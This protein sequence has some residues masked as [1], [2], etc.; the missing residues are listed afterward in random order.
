MKLNV[1]YTSEEKQ[2]MNLLDGYRLRPF[3]LQEDSNTKT[4]FVL[5]DILAALQLNL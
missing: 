4:V 3:V 5:M 2:H 1:F